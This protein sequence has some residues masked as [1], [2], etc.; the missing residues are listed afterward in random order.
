VNDH[1]ILIE[2]VIF[3]N[4][5]NER[6]LFN[7]ALTDG[8]SMPGNFDLIDFRHI[9]GTYFMRV[10]NYLDIPIKIKSELQ[11]KPNMM[12]K[13]IDEKLYIHCLESRRSNDDM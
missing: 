13:L 7:L 5:V 10:R 8:F 2:P 6:A 4:A 9:N 3:Q 11:I 1:P 12:I